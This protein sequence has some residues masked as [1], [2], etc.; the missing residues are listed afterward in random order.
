MLGLGAWLIMNDSSLFSLGALLAYRGFWW[1]L[2]S[3]IRT[4]AQT[5]DILQRA[6]AAA[7]RIMELL[8]KPVSIKMNRTPD[9]WEA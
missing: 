6:R 1:R 2:Q 8:D 4:I 9:P 7:T 3:P 5:S